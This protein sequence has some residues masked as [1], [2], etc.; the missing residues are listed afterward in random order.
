MNC[1]VVLKPSAIK[2]LKKLPIS[3]QKRIGKKLHFFFSQKEPLD[4]AA[5]L[6]GNGKVGDYRFKHGDYRV[7]FDLDN[8]TITILMI[9]HRRDVYRKK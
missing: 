4:Y 1:S 5:P 9:E 8:D 3:I 6:V 7:V 2:D